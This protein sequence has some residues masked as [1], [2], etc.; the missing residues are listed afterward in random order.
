M[1]GFD[2]EPHLETAPWCIFSLWCKW[3]D[4][5]KVRIISAGGGA[6]GEGPRFTSIPRASSVFHIAFKNP[7]SETEQSNYISPPQQ[8][9]LFHL[10]TS[11]NL[12]S[13]TGLESLT[14]IWDSCLLFWG[15]FFF[16]LIALI[17]RIRGRSTSLFDLWK[18]KAIMV[19]CLQCSHWCPTRKFEV[20]F[21]ILFV[22][23]LTQSGEG[24]TVF[25][26]HTHTRTRIQ[27]FDPGQLTP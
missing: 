9:W 19:M 7:Q 25:A 24:A 6:P 10:V 26:T 2:Y 13:S 8:Q 14:L 27:S 20:M 4:A 15:F 22:P 5:C 12:S 21:K 18:I 17:W 1:H 3:G 23:D 11:L 16:I